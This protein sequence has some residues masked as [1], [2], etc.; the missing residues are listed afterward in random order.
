ML[1]FD[2]FLLP[3]HTYIC[4]LS[5]KCVDLTS[6]VIWKQTSYRICHVLA[7][8]FRSLKNSLTFFS[9]NFKGFHPSMT[10]KTMTTKTRNN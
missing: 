5:I 8:G 1:R 2:V 9:L 4:A 10:Q 3:K 7:L 6:F